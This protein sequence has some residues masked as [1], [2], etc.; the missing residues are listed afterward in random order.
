M[1]KHDLLKKALMKISLIAFILTLFSSIVFSSNISGQGIKSADISLNKSTTSLNRLIKAIE[2]QTSYSFFYEDETLSDKSFPVELSDNEGTVYD[3][4]SEVSNQTGLA[5]RQVNKTIAI[6]RADNIE[7]PGPVTVVQ[8]ETKLVSGKV[9]DSNNIPL[10]GVSIVIKGTTKGVTTGTDGQ[11]SLNVPT[12]AE[13]LVFSFIGMRTQEVAIAGQSNINVVMHEETIGLDEIVAVGYSTQKKKDLTGAVAVVDVEEIASTPVAGVDMM[14]QG[15]MAGVNVVADNNPGGGVAVR[16]RGFSTVRNNDPLY[17]VDG[18]P[19]ESGLNLINPNDIESLQVLKDASSASI[20][21]SRAANGVVIITTKKGQKGKQKVTFDSYVGVQSAAKL[22][23]PLN[24]QEYGDCLWQAF[25]NDGSTP[26]DD[27]YGTGSTAVIPDYLDED[28]RVPSANVNWVD[29]ITQNAMVQS[30]NVGVS[31]G[32]DKSRHSFSVGY[33]GQDGIVKYTNYKRITARFNSDYRL[34]DRLSIGENFTVSHSWSNQAGVNSALGSVILSAYQFPSIAPIKD[35]DGNY[36]GAFLND[37]GNPLASLY[38]NRD[39]KKKRLKLF[40]NTYAELEIIKGL[41]VKTNFGIDYADYYFRDYDPAYEETGAT[42]SNDISTLTTE[43]NKKFTWTWTNT[44]SYTKEFGNHKIS[45]F[46]GMEAIQTHYEEFTAYR[47]DFAY[48][49]DN[50]RYLDAGDAS[51]A[52]NSGTGSSSSLAS[53]FAKVDYIYNNRYLCA[54][55]LRRDGSSKL[56]DNKWGNFPAFSLGW[57]VSEEDFFNIDPISNF[58]L[59]FGWGQNGNQDVPDYA[60]IESYAS[61]SYYSNYAIDGSQNSV[62]TG[63]TKTRNG[64]SDLKWE[65]TTQTNIGLD[66]GFLDNR[67]NVT[68][69]YFIKNTDDMLIERTYPLIIGGTNSTVWDNAGSMENKGFEFSIEYHSKQKN[70]FSWNASLNFS[71]VNNELKSLPDDVSYITLSTSTLHSINFDQEVSRSVVGQPI[72][73]FYVYK[74]LGIFQSQDE[75]DNYINSDGDLIQSEAQPGDLKFADTDGDGDLDSDDRTFVGNPHPDLTFGFNFGFNYKDFDF[76]AF[77]NGSIGNDIYDL[78]RYKGDFFDQS[79]YNKFDRVKNA[80][81]ESNTNTS[82]P[83]LSL[84]DLNNNIRPSSYYVSDGSYVRLKSLTLGYNFSKL[85]KKIKS[86]KLRVYVQAQNLLTITGYDGMD[87]E[88]GLQSYTSSNRNLDIGV[89]RGLYPT[90][91]TFMLG[92]NVGF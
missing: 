5:F 43:N 65:T 42:S 22:L 66:L 28:E 44:V 60:T 78:T 24:A 74:S 86:D 27:I 48:D 4:L 11:Y 30:Y 15:H 51:T 46:A 49:E 33:F 8:Q 67:L 16:V 9:S 69:D 72:A 25:E 23:T 18:V 54:F 45:A 31:N 73:S 39:D 26:S 76:Q 41:K 88:V 10:P 38:Y 79:T 29:A 82:I 57:R 56:G 13:T 19:V 92:V 71:H 91:R 47:E 40:G 62:S 58:K 1:K 61:S 84:D 7:Q 85:A 36:A 80:W 2:K 12:N 50:F 20:Y 35:L 59:R 17:I 21:G 70:D 75:I 37:T 81:T 64:N 52:E 90:S 6:K 32:S 89:D 83:R 14:I 55:T 3:I 87:P 53:Y 68:A 34:F 77:F 63:Y